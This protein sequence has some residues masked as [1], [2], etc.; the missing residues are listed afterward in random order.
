MF[1]GRERELSKLQSAYRRDKF[2]MAVM[3]GRRRV[4]KTRLITEF[5]GDKD[6]IYFSALEVSAK[7]NL[8]NLSRAIMTYETGRSIGS[9]SYGSF[10]ECF[11]ALYQISKE[12]RLIF[13]IDEYPY[14]A[15]SFPGISSLLQQ[16][17]DLK[18][19][20]TKLFI[21]LCGSSMSFM[22]NQV[23]GYES[24]LYGRRTMQFK[25]NPLDFWESRQ[26]HQNFTEE[27]KA[28]IYGITGGIPQYLEYIDDSKSLSENII[29]N[30]FDNTA[31]LY[32]EPGNLL[33]QELREPA[34]YNSIIT[35]I[36]DGAS[37][38]NEIST[39]A[40]M[41]NPVCS[42]YIKSLIELG[43]V[44]KEKPAME[45]DAKRSIY[46]LDDGM[47]RF[48]YRFVA[49]SVDRICQN[50][51]AVAYRNIEPQISD[52]MGQVFEEM[53]KQ[54]LWKLNLDGTI[55]FAK[56]ER[57]WGTN[58]QLKRQEE[59][60]IIAYD[61]SKMIFCECK[62][63]N[64]KLSR[65]VAE[66]LLAKS[67]MFWGKEKSFILFSKSGF[68]DDCLALQKDKNIKMFS[69]ADF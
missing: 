48:W 10:E 44:R 61:D 33:K 1:V 3:Y 9:F 25:I 26:F 17:I 69:L 66:E 59:I 8:S 36:A 19:K 13:V 22:E 4:G 32:D 34:L 41:D 56:A 68:T 11:D 40:G 55:D 54:F 23:L 2:E 49:P 37:R 60:D 35:A 51:G 53:C 57:W 63:R 42:K 64:E 18:F 24:P 39:K 46:R 14:L 67:E 31:Y 62:W 28:I 12:K 15:S 21:I 45:N 6:A 38:I 52:F 7:M 50:Q 5:M 20:E 30:F 47:F 29:D 65:R 58:P 27:E 16:Y 43:I